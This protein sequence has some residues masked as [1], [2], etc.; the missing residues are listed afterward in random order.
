MRGLVAAIAATA[1]I[2]G[3]HG[4]TLQTRASGKGYIKYSTVTGYFLQ[5]DPSTN[6]T[7]FD[8]VR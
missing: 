5:D 4:R 2:A 6:A 3:A 7:T 1:L 8:Y